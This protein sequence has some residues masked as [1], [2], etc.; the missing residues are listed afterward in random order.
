VL[1]NFEYPR[2]LKIAYIGA[3]EH[4]I[5][6]ILP[7]FQYA[8]IELMAMADHD[9]ERGLAAARMFGAKRFYPNHK[10]LL[11]KEEGLDAVM[12]VVGPDEQGL[13]RY[14]ELA[15]ETLGAGLHTWVDAPPCVSAANVSIFTNACMKRRKYMAVGF[16]RAFAPAYLKAAEL[17]D[18]G[19]LGHVTSYAMRF[20]LRL[21]GPPERR[22]DKG[23]APFLPFTS[24]IAL[25]YGLFGEV[26]GLSMLR[27][28]AT[29]AGVITFAHKGGVVG[30]VHLAVGQ[31]SAS[32][33]ERLEIVGTGANLVAESGLRLVC[34]RRDGGVSPELLG[35]QE[36]YPAEDP[37]H[38]PLF[39]EPRFEALEPATHQ[40]ALSGYL[41]SVRSFADQM[42]AGEP[43][44]HGT[45]IE[46]LHVMTVFDRIHQ[47]KE[48]EW[49]AV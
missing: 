44:Q 12:I 33:S 41:G 22:T 24:I 27:H 6:N 43:P 35:R 28:E 5:R 16:R 26:E 15:A 32:P 7:T 37:A 4:S 49:I 23:M 30:S 39:W 48:R 36:G 47:G 13:P 2:K 29:G 45:L 10:A 1:Y 25:L 11:A 31:A 8:P 14:P 3:G 40:V 19:T 46:V 38:A 21:P 42:L 17:L 20:P 9:T 34:Y 18:A